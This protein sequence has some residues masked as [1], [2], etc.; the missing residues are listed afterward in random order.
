MRGH[1]LRKDR[2][3]TGKSKADQEKNDILV[4]L[5]DKSDEEL[6]RILDELY[7]DESRLSYKRRIL[8]ARI[9]IVREELVKRMKDHVD[10]GE[11]LFGASTTHTSATHVGASP[12][13]A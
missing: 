10:K 8:H 1:S 12:A 6:R 4:T 2:I 13:H 11:K 9:D 3:V 5:T 7:G